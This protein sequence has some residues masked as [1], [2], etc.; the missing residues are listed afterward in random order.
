MLSSGVG[1]L[2]LYFPEMPPL[3]RL[4]HKSNTTKF[5]LIKK[6]FIRIY[7]PALRDYELTVYNPAERGFLKPVRYDATYKILFGL[8]VLWDSLDKI[9]QSRTTQAYQ[10]ALDIAHLLLLNYHPDI[11]Q[12][13]NHV[14]ALMFDMNKLWERFLETTLRQTLNREFELKSQPS[15][16]FWESTPM[17]KSS[18]LRPDIVLKHQANTYVIDTKWKNLTKHTPSSGDLQQLYAYLNYFKAQKVALIYPG[19]HDQAREGHFY[20]AN[21]PQECSII[22]LT[23]QESISTWQQSIRKTIMHWIENCT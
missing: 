8:K 19:D 23:P 21:S 18:S 22:T 6:C 10:K 16:K 17:N 4:S 7:T 2:L 14:L 12:G 15:K 20:Q 13:Q 3:S 1:K 11:S 9:P 5:S